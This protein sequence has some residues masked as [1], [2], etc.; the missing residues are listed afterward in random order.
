MNTF[1]KANNAKA[2]QDEKF[3]PVFGRA[4]LS[5]FCYMIAREKHTPPCKACGQACIVGKYVIKSGNIS[6]QALY[7]Y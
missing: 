1:Y 4:H 7:Y 5:F 2:M 3:R 6:F